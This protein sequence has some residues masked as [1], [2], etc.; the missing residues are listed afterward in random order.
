MR[1]SL[2]M[3]CL[4]FVSGCTTG[5]RDAI[6]R[7]EFLALAQATE[8]NITSLSGALYAVA[9][10]KY[11]QEVA[12]YHVPV[13]MIL[14]SDKENK[15]RIIYSTTTNFVAISYPVCDATRQGL[16]VLAWKFNTFAL[17]HLDGLLMSGHDK[18]V[19]QILC[20]IKKTNGGTIPGA[21]E[22]LALLR[23]HASKMEYK[24]TF[25][26]VVSPPLWI[27]ASYES[28]MAGDVVPRK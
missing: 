19:H 25:V 23:S 16:E 15:G 3:G 26:D 11:I 7:S 20:D 10:E 24:R 28:I 17:Y 2:A 8:Q 12:T 14:H 21:E 13:I 5:N 18:L 9:S 27:A 6:P 4:F 22:R 1:A